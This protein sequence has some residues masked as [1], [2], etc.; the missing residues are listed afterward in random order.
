MLVTPIEVAVSARFTEVLESL[1]EVHD[2]L[3]ISAQLSRCYSQRLTAQ[4]AHETFHAIERPI[5][6]V[7]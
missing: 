1:F 7:K 6:F 5:L 3:G 2:V 4:Y